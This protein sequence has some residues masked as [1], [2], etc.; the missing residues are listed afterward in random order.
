MILQ[1][2]A[3]N[4]LFSPKSGTVWYGSVPLFGIAFSQPQIRLQLLLPTATYLRGG[5]S[6]LVERGRALRLYCTER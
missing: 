6:P 4:A 5:A 2:C 1:F 3:K